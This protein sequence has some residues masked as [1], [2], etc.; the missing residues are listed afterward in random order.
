MTNHL[1]NAVTVITG[2]ASGIGAASARRL[3]ASG[4]KLVLGDLDE[5]GLKKVVSDIK[6]AGGTASYKLTD[7]ASYEAF[8]ALVAFAEETYGPVDILVNNAGL[9]LFSYWEERAIADWDKMIDVNLRGYLHGIAAVLPTMTKRKAGRI[10]NMDSVAGHR[11]GEAGG[12]YAA[13][14]F[15][16]QGMT[17]SLRKEVGVSSGIQVGM[18]SPGVIDTGW[19]HKLRDGKAKDVAVDLS[20]G[21]IKPE[22]VAEAVA[23]ALNQPKGVAINE[24]IVAPVDQAW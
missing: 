8:E 9:M 23:F 15:F 14:K 5:D 7:V 22:A 1:Q 24:I 6:D 18:V 21:S 4:A 2:A 10:I 19:P 3:A 20:K 13:T 11:A 16:I 12:V 17:E